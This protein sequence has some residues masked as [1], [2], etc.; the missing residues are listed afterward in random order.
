MGKEGEPRPNPERHGGNQPAEQLRPF[1][2]PPELAEFLK[3]KPY[4]C[5]PQATDR[6]TV[7]VVKAPGA[8]IE[9]LRGPVPIH[10]RHELY[11]H[12]HAPVVRSVTTLYD[13]PG[14]PLRL[15]TFVNV[16]DD[17]QRA[18]FAA[19]ATQEELYLLFYDEQLAHQLSKR[20][21]TVDPE[22]VTAILEQAEHLRAAIPAER[23]DFDRAK[24]AVL[25][26]TTL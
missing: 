14:R 8:D 21:P 20:M 3:D 24:A 15:E 22:T 4:A 12:P 19:L 16:A 13:Q 9:G 5:V 23:F 18:D 6:G 17:Q 7:L 25:R 11:E 2:L 1:E 26:H 10:Q